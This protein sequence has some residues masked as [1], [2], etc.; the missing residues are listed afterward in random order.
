MHLAAVS[1]ALQHQVPAGTIQPIEN[2]QPLEGFHTLQRRDP[3]LKD[4]DPADRSIMTALARG[5]HAGG[6]GCGNAADEGETR[7]RGCGR[8]DSHFI[9]AN[10]VFPDHKCLPYQGGYFMPFSNAAN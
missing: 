8:L 2:L 9:F 4:L 6:P 1:R 3:R 7:I 10:F 5:F